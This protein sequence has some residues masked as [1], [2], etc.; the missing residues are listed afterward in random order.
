MITID[1]TKEEIKQLHYERFHHP[2]PR[3][4]Q[5]MEVVYLKSQGMP[6][7]EIERIMD[8]HR[9]TVCKYLKCYQEKGIEGLK[10]L[11]FNRPKSKMAE[12]RS[13]I[14]AE[15]RTKPPHTVGE[16]AARIEALTGIK[17]SKTQVAKFLHDMGMK[18]RR[19]GV[20]PAKADVEKQEDFKKNS[21]NR[22]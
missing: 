19:V 1:F 9:L 11:T 15:F 13:S 6:N 14:E 18:P 16:A 2:H 7:A 4:Q 17:R 21:L 10:E 20:L 3:V 5:R 22:A 12:H 8:L